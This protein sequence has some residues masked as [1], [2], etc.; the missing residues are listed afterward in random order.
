LFFGLG[1]A[2]GAVVRAERAEHFAIGR[3][4]RHAPGP[5]EPASRFGLPAVAFAGDRGQESETE[6]GDSS[7]WS[8]VRSRRE[9]IALQKAVTIPVLVLP[10]RMVCSQRK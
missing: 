2:A 4:D 10:T 3:L 8:V 5:L 9:G 7:Q 1:S 6:T